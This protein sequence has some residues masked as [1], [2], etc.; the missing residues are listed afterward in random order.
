MYYLKII[1]EI[2]NLLF[3]ND[4]ALTFLPIVLQPAFLVTTMLHRNTWKLLTRKAASFGMHV[5]V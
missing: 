1:E 2:Y 4:G 3:S 5:C